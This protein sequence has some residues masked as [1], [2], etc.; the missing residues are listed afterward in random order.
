MNWSI[1]M[2]TPNYLYSCR[3]NNCFGISSWE[4]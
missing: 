2:Q 1:A 4:R 3:E